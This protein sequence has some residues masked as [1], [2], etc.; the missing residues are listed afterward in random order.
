ML[1]I[2]S[3]KISLVHVKKQ[4]YEFIFGVCHDP[5]KTLRELYTD[6]HNSMII[7]QHLLSN[8]LSSDPDML[9]SN[10]RAEV[11]WDTLFGRL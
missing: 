10:S 8:F 2:Q 11:L 9:V 1:I 3:S 7:C 6:P 4:K 5:Y